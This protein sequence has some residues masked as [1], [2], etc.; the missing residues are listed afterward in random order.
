MMTIEDHG[1]DAHT[2]YGEPHLF[3]RAGVELLEH[4]EEPINEANEAV[5]K[6]GRSDVGGISPD[7]VAFAL[8]RM[9]LRPLGFA[10]RPTAHQINQTAAMKHFENEWILDEI[11]QH[12]T[13]FTKGMFGGLAVYLFERQMLVLVEPT[14]SGRWNWHGVL[15]CTSHAHH[16]SIQA[17]LPALSPHALLS[18]WLFLESSHEDFEST[19]E[20]LVKRIDSNDQRF[21]IEPKP[22]KQ[23]R[24]HP[25]A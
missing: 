18:K 9:S 24:T 1:T 12:A 3:F 2:G 6:I 17:E 13:F 11:S 8:S 22:G 7:F 10:L 4:N 25:P 20:S 23:S 16:A 5:D 15:V 19:M 14:K 21:G